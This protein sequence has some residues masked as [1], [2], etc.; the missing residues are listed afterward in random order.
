MND[1]TDYKLIPTATLRALVRWVEEA[2]PPGHFVTACL[3][4]DMMKAVRHGD[5]SNLRALAA[6]AKWIYNRCPQEACFS[7]RP[8]K[9]EDLVWPGLPHDE[10][11]EWREMALAGLEGLS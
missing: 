8:G 7:F 2:L 4:G 11:K 5:L 1:P 9:F 6:I 10:R 3:E